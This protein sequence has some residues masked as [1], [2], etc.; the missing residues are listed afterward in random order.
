MN[1]SKAWLT[2]GDAGLFNLSINTMIDE[3]KPH[4]KPLCYTLEFP[5]CPTPDHPRQQTITIGLLDDNDLLLIKRAID[6][7]IGGVIL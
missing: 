6:Q 5:E 7:M 4:M 3:N 2:E 1:V